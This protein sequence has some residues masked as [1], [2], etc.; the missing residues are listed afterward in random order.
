MR[1]S[2]IS[3]LLKNIMLACAVF[4][5]INALPVPYNGYTIYSKFSIFISFIL[6]SIIPS[7]FQ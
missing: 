2:S 5:R 6:I 7:N 4:N 1:N 3:A